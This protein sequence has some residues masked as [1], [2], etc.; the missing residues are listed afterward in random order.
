MFVCGLPRSLP[1]GV[2]GY[3]TLPLGDYS[4]AEEKEEMLIAAKFST[5][6]FRH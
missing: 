4:L 3:N 1:V 5:I 2:K 6:G